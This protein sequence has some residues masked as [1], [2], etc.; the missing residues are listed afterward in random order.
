MDKGPQTRI[1]RRVTRALTSP[2]LPMALMAGFIV[3][4]VVIWSVLRQQVEQQAKL[5]LD[6]EITI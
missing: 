4:A 2:V 6:N 5:T 3:L 1:T